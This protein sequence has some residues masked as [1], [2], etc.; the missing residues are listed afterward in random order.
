MNESECLTD[1]KKGAEACLN[2][3][4]RLLKDAQ[5]LFEKKSYLSCFL[6]SQLCLEE[7]A[8]GFKLIDKHLNKE[9]FSR[10]EWKKLTGGGQAHVEKLKCLQEVEDAWTDQATKGMYLENLQKIVSKVNWANNLDDYREKL[11]EAVYKRWR[12][13]SVYV[14]YDWER[15][16]WIEPSKH[17]IF[18]EISIEE[19]EYGTINE[20]ICRSNLIRAER[21]S[22]ILMNKLH[23]KNVVRNGHE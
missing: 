14:D 18:K 7:L 15:K 8:K 6:L 9:N 12:L 19:R 5:I 21:L 3:A 1:I 23:T 11:S 20:N 13:P 22:Q 17:P 4:K 10:E 2:N 16:Q